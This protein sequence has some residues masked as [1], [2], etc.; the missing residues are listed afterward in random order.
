MSLAE[1]I[2]LDDVWKANSQ[3][4]TDKCPGIDAVL[5]SSCKSIGACHVGQSSLHLSLGHVACRSGLL[6]DQA[7]LWQLFICSVYNIGFYL[8]LRLRHW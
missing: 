4:S 6:C 2:T 1:P 8:F 3:L 5:T 7:P